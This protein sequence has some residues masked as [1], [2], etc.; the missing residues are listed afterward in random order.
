MGWGEWIGGAI[1]N[2]VGAVG[3]GLAGGFVGGVA[4]AGIGGVVGGSAGLVT[5]GPGGIVTGGAGAAA[6]G[7]V[8]AGAGIVGGAY[9]GG[10]AGTA[11]GG[12][13][14]RWID[15]QIAAMTGASEE[16]EKGEDAASPVNCTGDCADTPSAEELEGKTAEEI[17]EIMRQKGWK[18][19]PTANGQGTRYANPAR[20]GEQV[21]IM[22]NGTVGTSRPDLH[23]GPYG[24]VSKNGAKTRFS[25]R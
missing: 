18:G 3:G 24:I 14:G 5:T 12:G 20:P 16:S 13:A 17:E 6:G 21:R 22:P 19:E 7:L 8:G 11:V 9:Y 15:N 4:G 10:K 1:G 25:L 23:S 2:A